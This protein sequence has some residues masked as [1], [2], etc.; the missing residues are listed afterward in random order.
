MARTAG[1]C[2]RPINS[3]G[4]LG[5]RRGSAQGILISLKQTT[6]KLQDLVCGL[7]EAAAAIVS[8]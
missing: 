1:G 3:R 4:R 2:A 7:W 5:L 6:P 8:R